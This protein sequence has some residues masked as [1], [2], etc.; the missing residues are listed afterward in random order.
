MSRTSDPLDPGIGCRAPSD[1]LAV[2]SIHGEADPDDLPV[3]AGELKAVGA[4]AQVRGQDD[5][6]AVMGAAG[7]PA[8]MPL[9]QQAVQLH[10]PVDALVIDRGGALG[11]QVAVQ[12]RGDPPVAVGRPRLDQP[13]HQRQYRRVLRFVIAPTRLRSAL[14][15]LDQ[16]GTRHAQ[17]VR[18]GLHREPSQGR[19]LASKL[20]FFPC[21]LARASLRISACEPA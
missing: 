3:P 20:G 21:A 4:P 6:L 10:Q 17:G 13:P 2:V 11:R 14:Q 15:P 16:V 5:D 8:G 7:A 12:Q 19:D 1:D 18:N 9:Q